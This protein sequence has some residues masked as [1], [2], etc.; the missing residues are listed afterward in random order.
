M[1]AVPFAGLGTAASAVDILRARFPD[2]RI[3]VVKRVDLMRLQDDRE[4]PRGLPDSVFDSQFHR[5]RPVIFAVGEIRRKRLPRWSMRS[6]H[7]AYG[8]SEQFVLTES[9][10]SR[11]VTLSPKSSTASGS[12]RRR[13]EDRRDSLETGGITY[14]GVRNGLLACGNLRWGPAKYADERE[15]DRCSC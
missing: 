15:R 4:H 13:P 5:D 14:W 12:P 2:V 3:R 9:A 10:N 7:G 1:R 6:V 11:T 8:V